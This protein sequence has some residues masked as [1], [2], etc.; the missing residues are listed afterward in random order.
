ML[1]DG[2]EGS[3]MGVG[4]SCWD[5]SAGA[6][7]DALPDIGDVFADVLGVEAVGGGTV[8]DWLK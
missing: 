7:M 2:G 3:F 1:D 6:N 4:G 5:M 8:T